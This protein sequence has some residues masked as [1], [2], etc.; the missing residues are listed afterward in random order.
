MT[1]IGWGGAF[2]HQYSSSTGALDSREMAPTAC[3]RA[4]RGRGASGPG[5]VPSR[6]VTAMARCQAAVLAPLLLQF[7]YA[8][9]PRKQVPDAA[10][11]LSQRRTR[12]LCRLYTSFLHTVADFG[13]RSPL[14]ML[15]HRDLRTVISIFCGPLP[16]VN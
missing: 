9:Q 4:R 15:A 7:A 10:A 16:H 8:R 1:W 12:L 5:R 3:R 6:F 13:Q 2:V 11:T 14:E